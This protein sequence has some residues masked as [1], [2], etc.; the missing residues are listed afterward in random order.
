MKKE[1]K[2]WI[3]GAEQF[4]V[5]KVPRCYHVR[6]KKNDVSVMLVGFSDASKKGYAAVLYIRVQDRDGEVTVNL[7]ASKTRMA[8]IEEQS[9]PR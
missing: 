1:W 3:A 9:I 2:R 5:F 8:P 6:I 4:N 7:V